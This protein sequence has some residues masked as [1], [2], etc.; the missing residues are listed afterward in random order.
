MAMM[1]VAGTAASWSSVEAELEEMAKSIVV[2]EPAGSSK[3]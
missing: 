2:T 3:P 1:P